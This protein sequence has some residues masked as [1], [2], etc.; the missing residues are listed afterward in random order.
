LPEELPVYFFFIVVIFF[1]QNMGSV[2]IEYHVSGYGGYGALERSPL[3][4]HF[5]FFITFATIKILCAD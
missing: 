2:R 3:W 1:D 4:T 5:L